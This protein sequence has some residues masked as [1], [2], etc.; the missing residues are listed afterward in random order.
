M[1]DWWRSGATFREYLDDT[2][3]F[4]RSPGGQRLQAVHE[5]AEA[6][7]EAWLAD[8][9]GVVVHSHGGYAPEQWEGEVDG[10]SFYFRERDTDWDIEIDLRPSGRVM[11]VRD[12]GTEDGATPDQRDEIVE[13]DVVASGRTAAQ[14]Y[15]HSPRERAAF[16][17][18]TIREH[19]TRQACTHPGL[20]AIAA[21]L[22]VPARWCPR[23]GIRVRD[24][25]E[26][27]E[28]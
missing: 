22:G 11:R 26:M 25:G 5:A 2:D 6:D 9:P 24:Q 14:G 15:G 19:L 17:V 27:R 18:E 16:I 21:V 23:C 1:P 8:Q 13:G 7:L 10:H 20:Q 28:P 3:E 4:W 12:G